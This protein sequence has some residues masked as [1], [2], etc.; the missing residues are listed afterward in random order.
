MIYV[1]PDLETQVRE[2]VRA[3]QEAHECLE[4]MPGECVKRLQAAKEKRT[5]PG[6]RRP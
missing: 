3:Y 4:K 5:G 1:P 2:W 6:S